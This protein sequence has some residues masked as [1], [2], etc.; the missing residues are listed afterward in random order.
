MKNLLTILCL[1]MVTLVAGCGT[2]LHT[3]GVK[4]CD[5][6][7]S[8]PDVVPNVAGAAVG[9]ISAPLGDAIEG[10]YMSRV[11]DWTGLGKDALPDHSDTTDA[12]HA[13]DNGE[14][15]SCGACM[16]FNVG[17]ATRHFT[18]GKNEWGG[19]AENAPHHVHTSRCRHSTHLM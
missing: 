16:G 7:M 15:A 8:I 11:C 9:I 3:A 12:E 2:A 14:A 1:S 5:K 18:G 6:V 13:T 10:R 4:T 19:F 17:A